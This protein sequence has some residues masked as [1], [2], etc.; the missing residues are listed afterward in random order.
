MCD[1]ILP[2]ACCFFLYFYHEFRDYQATGKICVK[3]RHIWCDELNL[4]A[5]TAVERKK[6]SQNRWSFQHFHLIC[7]WCSWRE[8]QIMGAHTIYAFDCA[9]TPVACVAIDISPFFLI[10][11]TCL[12]AFK[13]V[14]IGFV[15][16]CIWYLSLPYW[17]LP[18]IQRSNEYA[19]FH[20]LSL[21][22]WL[23]E[24]ALCA[25]M[26]AMPPLASLSLTL[27]YSSSH[28]S[29]WLSPFRLFK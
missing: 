11:R 24:R 17:A 22:L 23:R 14:A 4:E 2:A 6:T 15:Y 7:H 29:L 10:G 27:S 21:S 9:V 16:L 12:S 28:F 25:R 19:P 26:T 5:K 8:K 18:M 13:H 20:L 3:K 1:V